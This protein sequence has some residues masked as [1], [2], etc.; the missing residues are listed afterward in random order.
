[1]LSPNIVNQGFLVDIKT[2]KLIILH[3]SY[4]GDSIL[5]K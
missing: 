4:V 3:Y 5:F 1:M 2:Q